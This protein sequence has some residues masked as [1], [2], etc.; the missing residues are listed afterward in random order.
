MCIGNPMQVLRCDGLEALCSDGSNSEVVD[1]ALVGQ[2]ERGTW[3]LVFLGAAREVMSEHDALQTRKALQALAAIA[4]GSTEIDHL[5]AD[6]NNREPPLP[7][8]LE[9]A[10][11]KSKKNATHIDESSV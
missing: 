5:F 10:A 9:A 3:L 11:K 1:L 6:L 7:P 2:Q 4:N 8:H